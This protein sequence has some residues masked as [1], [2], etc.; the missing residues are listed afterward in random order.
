MNSPETRGS[1]ASTANGRRPALRGP[2]PSTIAAAWASDSARSGVTSRFARPRTPS[3]PK[4][5]GMCGPFRRRSALREL[6][7]LPGLLQAGLLA[8]L[9]PCVA[10]EEAGLLQAA[11]VVLEVDLVERARDAEPQG[12]GLAGGAAAGDLRD[13]VVRALQPED[14]EG[15][16]DEL[17]VQL[18]REV[19]RE[20]AAVDGDRA[21]ARDEP[22]AG[23]RLLA[24][25]D[26]RAGD[27]ERRTLRSVGRRRLGAEGGRGVDGVCDAC[28][29]CLGLFARGAYCA[30]WFRV[31]CVGC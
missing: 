27:G 5:R 26:G 20:L 25:A 11:A 13:H 2:S 21:A 7:R 8:L 24:A 14:G 18:V 19:V 17:L 31:Y 23:D 28:H 29:G 3:V 30:T 6:R 9:H 12:T 16:G 1:R 15:V 4:R 22:D 10:G